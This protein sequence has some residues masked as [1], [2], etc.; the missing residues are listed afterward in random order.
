MFMDVTP[1][2]TIEVEQVGDIYY[3]TNREEIP[4][5]VQVTVRRP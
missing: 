2:D 5:L 3:L 1:R 4:V